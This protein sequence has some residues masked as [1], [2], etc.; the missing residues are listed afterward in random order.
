MYVYP[1]QD[2][3]DVVYNTSLLYEI[4]VI[5]TYA[6]PLLFLLEESDPNYKEAIRLLNLLKNVLPIP[7]DFIPKDSILREFIG[8]SYFK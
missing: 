6:E 3:A 5:K 1:Y 2:Q 8:D 7:T 4:G